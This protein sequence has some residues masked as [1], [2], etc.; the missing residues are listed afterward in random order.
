[1]FKKQKKS[2]INS[3]I[4]KLL[5]FSP[6][7]ISIPFFSNHNNLKAGLEFQ[8][9]SGKGYKRLNWFQTDDKRRAR[10]SIF[11]FFRPSDRKTGLLKIN[12]KIPKTFKTTLKEEKIS[13]CRVLIGGFD[14]RTKCLE[15]IPADIE[16]N[17]D[18]K[19]LDI[20]PY[21]PIPYDKNSYAVVL[22]VFNP[23]MSG[24]YQFH[25]FGEAIGSTAVPNYL[26]SWTIVID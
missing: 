14:T 17:E 5:F 19:S 7:L 2:F 20:F 25:S 24:L 22:K 6:L 1:M 21:A 26:G 4:L 11:F 23:I 13:F 18:K 8:W 15:N 9:D 12:I 10:N 3:R 16:L